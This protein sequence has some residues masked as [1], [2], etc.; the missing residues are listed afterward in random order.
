MAAHPTGRALPPAVGESLLLRIGEADAAALE[1]L[2]HLCGDRFFSMARH[3]VLDEGAARE[4]VQDCFLRIW[5]RAITYHPAASSPFT[6]CVMILR[7]LC[8]DHLR[9]IGRRIPP[10][11]GPTPDESP[12]PQ[13]PLADLHLHETLHL[14]RK[15]IA[16]LTPSEQE[17]ITT[18]LFDPATCNELA[19]RWQMPLGSVKTRIHRA[20]EK[21]RHLV[22]PHLD[23]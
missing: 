6:W 19:Q 12:A 11:S 4:I 10:A 8:F 18:A 20:M 14:L 2:Y 1:S 15:S 5:Q 9:R 22:R 23:P 17:T 16:T 21:L 3:L 7:G 13:S